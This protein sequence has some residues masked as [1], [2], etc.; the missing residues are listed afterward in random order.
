MTSGDGNSGDLA[1]AL[2]A[3]EKAP[4]IMLACEGDDMVLA[5]AN[6]AARVAFGDRCEFGRPV[7]EMAPEVDQRT[8]ELMDDMVVSVFATG[9]SITKPAHRVQVR[10]EDHAPFEVFWD[11]TFSPWFADDGSVRGVLAHGIDVTG[12]PRTGREPAERLHEVVALQDALL[13]GWLPVLPG[14]EIAGRYLLAESELVAGGDWYDAM[15]LADGRVAL[16]VGDVAGHGVSASAAMGRLRAVVEERLISG[17]D[18]GQVMLALDSFASCVPEA[19]AATVCVLVLDPRTGELEYCTAGHPPPL[20]VR[21]DGRSHYLRHSGAAP[22]ATTGEMSVAR[23]HVECGDLVLLYTDGLLVRPGRSPARS[24]VE[25]G[26]VAADAAASVRQPGS[27]GVADRVCQ[28]ALEAMTRRSGYADDIAVLVAEV[29]QPSV[30]LHLELAADAAAVPR[31]LD[32]LATWLESLR[33]RELDHIVVQH[34]VDELVTNVVDHAYATARRPGRLT[35]DAQLLPTGEVEITFVDRG[36]WVPPHGGHGRGHGLRMVRGMVDRL[37]VRGTE[38]GTVA[39]VR[40]RLSRPAWML[41]G[42]TTPVGRQFAEVDEAFT[43]AADDTCLHLAGSLDR[44]GLDDLRGALDDVADV[45][46]VVLDLE[47]VTRLPSSAVQVLHVASRDA[48]DR[49]QDLVLYAPAG[50]TA[51]QVLELVRLPYVLTEPQ[52]A[53]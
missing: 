52:R 51:Q 13:P 41:T 17:A 34:A 42:S 43:L 6:E 2:G 30:P 11:L 16:V 18:L 21:P 26:Q 7:R 48:A 27:P 1:G 3:Y 40:H 47:G 20:V 22:L 28:Q 53:G 38:A 50:T 39:I 15:G 33:V 36:S 44:T 32:A 19:Y 37:V 23:D 14:V 5:S 12:T 46:R 31:V 10:A 49:G 25:L 8:F 45:G 29:I 4:A 24:T 9:R 35:I